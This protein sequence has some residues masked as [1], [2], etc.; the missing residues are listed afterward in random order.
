VQRYFRPSPR[1]TS[2]TVVVKVLIELA[3][4]FGSWSLPVTW[5]CS[6]SFFAVLSSSPTMGSFVHAGLRW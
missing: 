5:I 4:T 3:L 1:R 6:S 2:S